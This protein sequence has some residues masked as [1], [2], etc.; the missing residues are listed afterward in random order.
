MTTLPTL[1]LQGAANISMIVYLRT[2][3]LPSQA[4]AGLDERL[5]TLK[6]RAHLVYK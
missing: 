3:R 5:A 2:Y 4:T 1:S 6:S